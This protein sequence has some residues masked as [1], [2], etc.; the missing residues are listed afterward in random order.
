MVQPNSV[1]TAL[2]TGPDVEPQLAG[3]PERLQDTVPVGATDP[4]TPAK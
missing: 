3:P 4:L 2:Y 1:V